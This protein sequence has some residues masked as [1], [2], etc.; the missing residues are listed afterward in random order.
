MLSNANT[1]P[2][3]YLSIIDDVMESIREL[4]LEEGVEER[5]LEDLRQLWESKVL[6]SKA[7][8]GFA[9]D[10]NPSNFVLQLPANFSQTLQKPTVVIPAG[11]HAQSFTTKSSQTG[12]IATFSL[13]PGVTYPVHIP[14]G[15]TLQTAS[16]HLYKVNVPVMVTQA[17]SCQRVSA[18]ANKPLEEQRNLP[19]AIIH[20]IPTQV[21]GL[22]PQTLPVPQ[23]SRTVLPSHHQSQLPQHPNIP[24]DQS[25]QP[26]VPVTPEPSINHQPS[27]SPLESPSEFT[28]DGIEFSPQPVDMSVSSPLSTQLPVG[29]QGGSGNVQVLEFGASAQEMVERAVK[30]EE[31]AAAMASTNDTLEMELLRDYN[32]NELASIVQLDGA[33]DSSS[34]AG[35]EEQEQDEED[36]GAVGEN[37]FLGIINAEAL[38]ALQ[39]AGDPLNSGD[40]VS[41]QDIPEI[42]DTENV[43]VCQYDKIHR[44]KN[45]WKFYLKDGVMCYSGKDYV[46]SKAVGEAEW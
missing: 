3:L 25:I 10:I 29:L 9:K 44:S 40:D 12:T 23:A 2:K 26:P 31:E 6:Q 35:E 16:G 8:E 30:A 5:V 18:Q 7:V 21:T 37:E 1:L 20:N 42:F 34:E 38:K 22:C 15:V 32:F 45:R 17:P 24:L 36:Q 27:Q 14:A 39:G 19:T 41:E 43:I 11:Q 4:F 33:C 28:L 13:P 46:F